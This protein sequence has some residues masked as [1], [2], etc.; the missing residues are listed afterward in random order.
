LLSQYVDNAS[1]YAQAG[2]QIMIEGVEKPEAVILSVRSIGPVIPPGDQE[3]I[4]DRYFRSSHSASQAP[5]T[6]IGL[7]IAKQAAQAHGGHVWVTSTDAGVTTFFASFPR[8]NEHGEIR[9]TIKPQH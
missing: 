3:R 9:W 7:S 2:T 4:F 6:G 1:K 8:L 5:G